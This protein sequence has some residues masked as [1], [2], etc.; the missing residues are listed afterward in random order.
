MA[1]IM[2][3][4]SKPQLT[5]SGLMRKIKKHNVDHKKYPLLVVGIRGYYLNTMGKKGANDR[6][7]YDDAIFLVTPDVFA[8]FN[9]NVDPSVFR[10]RIAT[11]M[12]GIYY[13]YKFD[14]HR[15]KNKKYWHKAICQR[16]GKVTV[17][18]DG[19]KHLD[20]GNFG[21]NI[22]RGG[23][24]RTSSLGCQTLPPTQ[25]GAFY[26]LA[27]MEAKR[28]FGKEWNKVTIPYILI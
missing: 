4:K 6:G 18:R 10:T 19:W 25:Y 5:R 7:I 23:R 28:L 22:H 9:A 16:K 24:T 12:P 17:K 26:G 27:E 8:S 15:G 2:K 13:S 14:T 21:I 11:L 20:K 1:K 3:P